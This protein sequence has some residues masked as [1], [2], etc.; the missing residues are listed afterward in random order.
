MRL[1]SALVVVGLVGG[2]AALDYHYWDAQGMTFLG[3]QL[4]RI[5][6]WM[7]FWR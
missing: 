1:I 2:L 6:D 3:K 4:I 7:R 5:T